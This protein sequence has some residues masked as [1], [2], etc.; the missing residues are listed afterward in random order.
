MAAELP[1]VGMVHFP[2]DP[3]K[4]WA[5]VR[6]LTPQFV[7]LRSIPQNSFGNHQFGSHICWYSHVFPRALMSELFKQHS[8][9]EY[10]DAVINFE[11]VVRAFI[12]WRFA[13]ANGGIFRIDE[14]ENCHLS[15][16]THLG[17]VPVFWMRNCG[18]A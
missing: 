7:D 9:F 11:I 16:H 3:S 18:D 15:G 2:K 13:N 14:E 12:E 5:L 1:N 8:H 10:R 6:H 17:S 4:V